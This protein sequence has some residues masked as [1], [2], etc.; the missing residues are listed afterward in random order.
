[1]AEHATLHHPDIL[2]VGGGVV[3]AALAYE[4]ARRGARVLLVERGAPASGASGASMGM[5]LWVDAGDATGLELA[6]RGMRRYDTLADELAAPVGFRPRKSLVLAYDDGTLDGLRRAADR[7][8]AAGMAAEIVGAADLARHEPALAA[9][10]WAGALACRQGQVHVARLIDAYLD[11]ARRHG[12]VVLAQTEV[13]GFTLAGDRIA[14]VRTTQGS[15]AA[16]QVLLAAG[17]WTRRLAA[18]LDRD[19]PIYATH[20]QA[21]ITAPLPPLL[22]TLLMVAPG[23]RT[24]AERQAVQALAGGRWED[25]TGELRAQDCAIAQADDGRVVIGQVSRVSARASLPARE[26]DADRIQAAAVRLVP[27]LQHLALQRTWVAPVPFTPDHRP[28][29]GPLGHLVNLWVAAGLKSALSQA[30]AVA[31]LLAGWIIEGRGDP[32]LV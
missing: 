11:A 1:M 6:R 5:A 19:L 30:P 23:T 8:R 28:L 18:M 9:D 17:A 16:G 20:G 2:I 7:F 29:L 25:W 15:I 3:G 22:H 24:Q 12:A 31:E 32:L 14:Q 21:A 26:E 13:T 10:G 27:A 4:L